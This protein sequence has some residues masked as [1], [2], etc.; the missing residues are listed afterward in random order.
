MLTIL[1]LVAIAKMV[2]TIMMKMT[3]IKINNGNAKNE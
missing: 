2:T 3:M 1:M